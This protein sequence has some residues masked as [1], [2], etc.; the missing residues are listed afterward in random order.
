MRKLTKIC[1][2]SERGGNGDMLSVHACSWFLLRRE[3]S[4]T[5]YPCTIGAYLHRRLSLSV[6]TSHQVI[7]PGVRRM[8][9]GLSILFFKVR[10]LYTVRRPL[11]GLPSCPPQMTTYHGTASWRKSALLATR[12]QNRIN[13][14]LSESSRG[15][16]A[17]CRS[18]NPH[19]ARSEQ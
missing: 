12:C 19:G 15:N 13:A 7:D 2:S 17:G 11:C 10:T 16:D 5:A 1:K 18:L 14:K 3:L 6:V 9:A 4:N 8:L